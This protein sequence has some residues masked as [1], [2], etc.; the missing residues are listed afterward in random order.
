MPGLRSVRISLFLIL[1]FGFP[2]L[3][4]QISDTL[5]RLL[6]P[7]IKPVNPARPT[8]EERR[9][10]VAY[11]HN[12][13]SPS[14][15][16]IRKEL[17]K[18]AW[19]L[20]KEALQTTDKTLKVNNNIALG[21]Y[22]H[23]SEESGGKQGL[24]VPYYESALYYAAGDS[25]FDKKIAYAWLGIGI[26]RVQQSRYEEAAVLFNKALHLFTMHKDTTGISSAH[27]YFYPLYSSMHLF[28]MAIQEQNL[29][30]RYMTAAERK[31]GLDA[32]YLEENYQDK[33]L[34]YLS[35]YE[36]TGNKA[37]LDSADG[38]I[39]KT[40][41]VGKNAARGKAFHYFLKGYR[42][43]LNSE[44]QQA[45]SNI[46]SS[47]ALEE[48]YSETTSAKLIYKG[49]SLLK[50]GRKNEGKAVLLD[51]SIVGSDYSLEVTKFNALYLDAL[52]EKKYPEAINYKELADKYKDSAAVIEQ[53]GK[54]FEVMQKYALAEKE[55]EIKNLELISVKRQEQRNTIILV[56]AI[57]A[58]SLV[59]IIIALYNRGKDRKFKA[60]RA[61]DMLHKEKRNLEDILMLQEREIQ[62]ERRKAISNLRKKISRDM[63]DELSNALAGLKYYV[64]DL[65]LKEKDIYKK[66]LIENIE[67]EVDSVYTQARA[68]MHNLHAGI[69]EAVGNLNPFL[70]HISRDFSRNKGLN[71][72]LK[73]D[74]A[75]VESRLSSTQQNQITL[76]LKEA[77]SNIL[78]HSGANKIEITISFNE[79]AC[80]FSIR[81]NGHGFEKAQL[82]KGLGM[83]SMELRIKRIKGHTTVRSSSSGTILKGSFPL[84]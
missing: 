64:N 10:I 67:Q 39:D 11:A 1:T 4:S 24:W 36:V 28:H 57:V 75:E 17:D 25:V 83:E 80:H 51:T 69:E 8:N 21:D 12:Y 78:K 42:S 55:I 48:F 77:L 19:G 79:N 44:Y 74:K 68:Y 49:I 29:M 30:L 26:Y 34:T 58:I 81:D 59:A 14:N 73:Y 61:E 20:K 32:Y 7:K 63:H 52:E 65:R 31:A 62:R 72:K 22:Y 53:R 35:W 3:K 40:P 6:P 46:D 45:L 5:Y 47:L 71:I 23:F 15:I 54:V 33:A 9:K 50:L 84:V 60:I 2:C 16:L 41:L 37:L 13:V 66:E 18:L 56:F 43:F 27:A 70:Q 38:Y 82:E 76:L